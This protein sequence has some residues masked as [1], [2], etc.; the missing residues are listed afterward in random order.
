[1]DIFLSG[2][3]LSLSLCLDI[4]IVNIAIIDSAVKRGTRAG[5][6]VGFG[7]CIGDLFYATLSAF[8]VAW[9]LRF[10]AVQ[11]TIWIGGTAMLLWL[12]FQM[13]KAAWQDAKR[14]PETMP[15][16]DTP[17][18]SNW[19]LVRRGAL[20]ALASPSSLLWFAAVGAGLIAEATAGQTARIPLF[21]LGFGA[22]GM[23]W[24]T[25]LAVMAT[26]GGSLL[27]NRLRQWCHI[28]S[29]VLFLYFTAKVGW[30]GYIT[31]WRG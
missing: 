31:L 13:A 17:P 16:L 11:W 24:S 27:G 6:M 23:V 3:L 26:Q 10:T 22:A 8:G 9:L 12:A 5:V 18:P 7:S 14:P 4:G 21:L 30:N 25:G 15:P 1:M 2:F 20:L 29:A 28:A 19:L